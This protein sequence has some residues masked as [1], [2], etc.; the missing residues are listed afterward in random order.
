P[1]L[2]VDV[3]APLKHHQHAEAGYE[4][5][6]GADGD[7]RKQRISAA[8]GR[9]REDAQPGDAEGDRRDPLQDPLD[10]RRPVAHPEGALLAAAL[11]LGL[12]GDAQVAVAKP[13][14]KSTR[15]NS[16]HVSI[17]YAVFCLKKKKEKL[18]YPRN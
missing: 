18:N 3:A 12:E 5:R 8:E 11:D 14:R 13:D 6:A 4:T 16:S 2:R 1:E 9:A 10:E 17:S 15:L 7:Q